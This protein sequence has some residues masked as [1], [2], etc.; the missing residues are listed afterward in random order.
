[1]GHAG[2]QLRRAKSC[3]EK[4]DPPR[5]R[6][7]VVGQEY[8]DLGPRLRDRA[9]PSVVESGTVLPDI[10]NSRHLPGCLTGAVVV[11]RVVNHE[12]LGGR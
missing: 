11:R 6:L 2:A 9:I 10:P 12:N 3:F 4:P 7:S 5:L 8:G 1:M